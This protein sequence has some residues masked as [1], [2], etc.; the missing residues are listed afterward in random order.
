[1]P[2]G[3]W[4][5]WSFMASQQI[6]LIGLAGPRVPVVLALT[7]ASIYIGAVIRSA[8]GAAG[9]ARVGL[10]GLAV[11]AAAFVSFALVNVILSR[12]YPPAPYAA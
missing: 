12:R 10:G 9:T 11:A 8:I 3:S 7:A 6:R 5:D 1:M 2:A 4:I